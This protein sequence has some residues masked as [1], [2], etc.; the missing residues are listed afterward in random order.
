LGVG[1]VSV[2]ERVGRLATPAAPGGTGA[3]LTGVLVVAVPL[4]AEVLALAGP[5]V[6]VAGVP[7]CPLG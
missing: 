3:L 4:A 1:G 6:R 2:G 7:V 5:L